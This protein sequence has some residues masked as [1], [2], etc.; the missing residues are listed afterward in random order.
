MADTMFT[1]SSSSSVL[2]HLLARSSKLA[3]VAVALAIIYSIGLAVYRIYFHPLSKYPGPFWAKVT[4]FYDFYQ[5]YSEHRAH[6]ILALHNKYGQCPA[7]W[8]EL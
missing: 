7:D 4:P 2:S 3:T 1:N 6:N 8:V 5:A